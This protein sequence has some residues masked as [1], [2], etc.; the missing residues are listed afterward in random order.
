MLDLIRL[1]RYTSMDF[2]RF[3]CLSKSQD[4]KGVRDRASSLVETFSG[5]SLSGCSP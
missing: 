2:I 1:S 5:L 3:Y 4:G